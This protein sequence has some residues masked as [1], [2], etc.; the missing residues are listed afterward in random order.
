MRTFDGSVTKL[1]ESLSNQ[2]LRLERVYEK[3]ELNPSPLSPLAT[4]ARTLERVVKMATDR[5]QTVC[6]GRSLYQFLNLVG[7]GTVMSP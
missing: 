4:Q 5:Q 2:K 7:T 6:I 1:I 3:E